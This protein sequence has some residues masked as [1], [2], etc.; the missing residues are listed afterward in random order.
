MATAEPTSNHNE[1]I[2]LSLIKKEISDDVVPKMNGDSSNDE[3]LLFASMFE[4]QNAVPVNPDQNYSMTVSELNDDDVDDDVVLQQMQRLVHVTPPDVLQQL[5]HQQNLLMSCHKTQQQQQRQQQLKPDLQQQL[6]DKLRFSVLQQTQL[7][8]QQPQSLAAALGNGGQ[9]CGDIDSMVAQTHLQLQQQQQQQQHQQLQLLQLLQHHLLLN[10]RL[11]SLTGNQASRINASELFQLWTELQLQKTAKVKTEINDIDS[12][13][14]GPFSSSIN[15]N[16]GVSSLSTSFSSTQNNHRSS[17]VTALQQLSN[18]LCKTTDQSMTVHNGHALEGESA[19]DDQND[20]S[21]ILYRHGVCVWPGC[22]SPCANLSSFNKHVHEEHRQDGRSTAQLRVQMQVVNQLEIQLTKEQTRLKAMKEHLQLQVGSETDSEPTLSLP[23]YSAAIS[24][25]SR[26]LELPSIQTI[27]RMPLNAV[28]LPTPSSS[29]VASVSE[30]SSSALPRSLDTFP[31]LSVPNGLHIP[32][33]NAAAAISFANLVMSQALRPVSR[34]SQTTVASQL[35]NS[36]LKM[37][38][39]RSSGPRGVGPARRRMSDKCSLPIS[40]EIQRNRDFYRYSDV[41]PPFTYAT[42]I[43]QAIMESPDRQLTLND[44]YQWFMSTFAFFRKNLP[45]WKNAVRHNLSLHK[46]F[47]RVE[48]VKG[49]VWTV[50]D[51]AF[52]RQHSSHK[53]TSSHDDGV[54]TENLQMPDSH[55]LTSSIMAAFGENR[56]T[57]TPSG[58]VL[59]EGLAKTGHEDW[60]NAQD[61]SAGISGRASDISLSPDNGLHDRFITREVFGDAAVEDIYTS[62]EQEDWGRIEKET[63]GTDGNSAFAPSDIKMSV[64]DDVGDSNN[65]IADSYDNAKMLTDEQSGV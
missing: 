21:K 7:L 8:A 23:K 44:I 16:S 30:V 61:L 25:K 49:A 20:V 9:K 64:Q 46:C 52:Y 1:A 56:Q 53:L 12:R 51:A 4:Q 58:S 65:I 32:T 34:L 39:S 24:G 22:D 48:N 19:A 29:S 26:L 31:S 36:R 6:V 11:A 35:A 63:E 18:G 13:H 47:T 14:G 54:K 33:P 60:L 37:P 41:R 59:C 27:S 5:L 50:D 42:L 40:A 28:P 55:S 62:N 38:G 15:S 2:D 45:T 17:P 3:K 10:P 57:L 43:R